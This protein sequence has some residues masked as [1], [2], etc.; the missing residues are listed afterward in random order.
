MHNC[1]VI[2]MLLIY[3]IYIVDI[4]I[5]YDYIINDLLNIYNN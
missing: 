4:F 5:Y 1:M 2:S 3:N